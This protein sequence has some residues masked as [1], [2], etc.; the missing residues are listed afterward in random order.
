MLSDEQIERFDRWWNGSKY[1]Q[2][3]HSNAN[4]RQTAL[5]GWAACLQERGGEEPAWIPGEPPHPWKTEWFIAKTT[6]G[7]RVVLIALP[8]EFTYDYK[9]ADETYIMADK[10]ECWMQF[11]DTE[12]KPATSPPDTAA[13][14][15]ELEREQEMSAFAVD[16]MLD[17][18]RQVIAKQDTEL[19]ALRARIKELED[20]EPIGVIDSRL[21]E[22]IGS[23][24]SPQLMYIPHLNGNLDGTTKLYLK[25]TPTQSTEPKDAE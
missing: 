21:L 17:E 8:E 7:D 14:I 3:V 2:V 22:C 15:A 4:A 12:Y 25:P 11:P 13:Q 16:A 20:Q 5:D 9:T 6:Y 23:S 18:Y 24:L 10:I 1:M 19:I